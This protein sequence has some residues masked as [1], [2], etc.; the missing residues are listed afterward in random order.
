MQTRR[1]LHRGHQIAKCL[2]PD[3]T[4]EV[5]GEFWDKLGID[6][7]LADKVIQI[8]YDRRIAASNN[9]YHEIYEKTHLLECQPWRTSIKGKAD[10]YIFTTETDTGCLG[11]L[12][13]INELAKH[14]QDLPLRGIFPN[15]G[16]ATSLGFLLRIPIVG[17]VTKRQSKFIC[18]RKCEE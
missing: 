11:I 17:C 13:S 12:I 8:K 15:G 3:I 1:R 16:A 9:I 10:H 6:A 18:D 2:W 5:E 4:F 14:E 7:H